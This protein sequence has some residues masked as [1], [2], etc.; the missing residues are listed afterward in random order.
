[1]K[2]VIKRTTAVLLAV[3]ILSIPITVMQAAAA[4]QGKASSDS[5]LGK[6]A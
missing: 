2:R 4:S 1:M 5:A 6:T 3:I